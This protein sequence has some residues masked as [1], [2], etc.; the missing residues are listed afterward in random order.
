MFFSFFLGI[1][2]SANLTGKNSF[3]DS[4]AISIDKEETPDHHKKFP[5]SNEEILRF[6][7][8]RST[9]SYLKKIFEEKIP[10]ERHRILRQM[11]ESG[12]LNFSIYSPIVKLSQIDFLENDNK[13]D[14]QLPEILEPV[15]KSWNF[16]HMP[17]MACGKSELPNSQPKDYRLKYIY[18]VMVPESIVKYLQITN[19]WD[20][21][22]AEKFFQDGE[23]RVTNDELEEFDKEL[24]E[25][26]RREKERMLK[27]QYDPTD[28]SDSEGSFDV[29]EESFDLPNIEESTNG[30]I[31]IEEKTGYS[32]S[33]NK[34]SRSRKNNRGKRPYNIS[35]SGKL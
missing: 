15:L 4:N 8:R 18:N 25:D 13:I 35:N 30:K 17:T 24:E 19:R 16:S 6:L 14:Q 31:E 28:E 21:A 29:Y 11:F 9:Q 23:S 5:V 20:K 32:R 33:T 2:S 26:A 3:V 34:F 10:S 22:R 27:E 1:E 7:G 12:K